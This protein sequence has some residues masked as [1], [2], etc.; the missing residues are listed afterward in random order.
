MSRTCSICDEDAV[1]LLLDLGLQPLSNRFLENRES[2]VLRVPFSFGCCRSCGVARF[3]NPPAPALI[4]PDDD[5]IRYNEPEGHLDDM[6]DNLLAFEGIKQSSTFLGISYKEESTLRRLNERGCSNTQLLDLGITDSRAG[7][8]TIQ[9]MMTASAVEADCADVIVVRHL[10]EHAQDTKQVVEALNKMLRPGGVLVYEV[11]DNEKLFANQELCFLWEE[12]VLYF[13]PETFRQALD[14]LG[15]RV[16][17]M[18]S[19]PYPVEN[20]L[21]AFVQ[22]DTPSAIQPAVA[23]TSFEAAQVFVSTVQ[24]DREWIQTA[25]ADRRANGQKVAG[26]GAGHLATRFINFY[27]IAEYLDFV[28]DD[29]PGKQNKTMAG[30]GLSILPGTELA[31]QGIDLALMSLNSESEERVLAKVGKQVPNLEFVSMFRS[32][33]RAFS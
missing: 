18:K 24:Q 8:E 29:H 26:F 27:N 28:A 22:P 9:E 4:R 33:L 7:M 1:E 14:V 3:L 11:P 25:L 31:A 30:S 17:R 6:V 32:S 19:Y 20:S 23:R 5:W 21:V 2:D 13:L 10:L 15:Y 16:A 12:H